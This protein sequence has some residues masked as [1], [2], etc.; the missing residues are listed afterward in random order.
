MASSS[1]SLVSSITSCPVDGRLF[2]RAGT[3]SRA[4]EG[5]PGAENL[6]DDGVGMLEDG[7]SGAG[8]E[9][10]FHDSGDGERESGSSNEYSPA[11]RLSSLWFC[12]VLALAPAP[13]RLWLA[14][15]GPDEGPSP[16]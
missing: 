11:K 4:G 15:A 12:D 7:G 8:D 6:D 14:P 10:R 3:T 2:L 1:E 16:K 9:D 13:A 5:T